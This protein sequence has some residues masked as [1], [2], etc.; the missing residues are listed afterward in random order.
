MADII[1]STTG[2]L[3]PPEL[4]FKSHPIFRGRPVPG[5]MQHAPLL[6]SSILRHV[7]S[8]SP[9]VEVF[10]RLTEEPPTAPL[11]STTY[12]RVAQRAVQLAVALAQ[13]YSVGMGDVVGTLSFNS[14]RHLEAYFAVSGMGAILHTIN[15]R[16]FPDQIEFIINHAADKILL[17][18]FAC[19]PL[20]APLIAAGKLHCKHFI[21]MCGD[22]K[23]SRIPFKAMSYEAIIAAARVPANF[24]WPTFDENTASSLCYTSG[25]TGHP[26]G[27]LFSHRSTLLHTYAMAMADS[28]GVSVRDTVL[29]I[30]PMVTQQRNNTRTLG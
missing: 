1:L 8:N 30:V 26:K 9:N 27:V 22:D 10:T 21:I 18:D 24:D 4:A 5:L 14:Y 16:L 6:I 12:S 23:M 25:T 19:A 28:T 17:I 29:L 11:H 20:V 15:P 3:Q 7:V 2:V 13:Q